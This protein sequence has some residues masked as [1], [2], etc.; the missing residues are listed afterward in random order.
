MTHIHTCWDNFTLDV[1]DR[2]IYALDCYLALPML[3][4]EPDNE[5]RKLYGKASCIRIK[6]YGE[7]TGIEY[8]TL[9]GYAV[10]SPE[11]IEYLWDGIQRAVEF[12]KSDEPIG[13]WEL[14]ANTIDN[15]DLETARLIMQEKNVSI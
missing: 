1:A 13:D 4:L 2:L 7:R 6:E 8:R 14:V 3:F 5:R 12:V 15:C 9:S 10:S 11:L